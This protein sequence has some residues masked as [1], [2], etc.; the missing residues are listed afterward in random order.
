MLMN[1]K[2]EAIVVLGGHMFLHYRYFGDA[3][4]VNMNKSEDRERQAQYDVVVFL[5]ICAIGTVMLRK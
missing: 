1:D 4:L 5:W 2:I 3:W